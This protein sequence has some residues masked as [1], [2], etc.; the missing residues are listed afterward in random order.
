MLLKNNYGI[1][2]ILLKNNYGILLEYSNLFNNIS[3]K[4]CF[5]DF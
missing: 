5:C 4:T 3:N 1:I 2:I